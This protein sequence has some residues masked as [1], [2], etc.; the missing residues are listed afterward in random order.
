MVLVERQQLRNYESVREEIYGPI[1]DRFKWEWEKNEEHN[2][3]YALASAHLVTESFVQ[4]LNTATD[5]MG[6]VFSKTVSVMEKAP[7]ETL[8]ELG[9]PAE[10]VD[11]VRCSPF[12]LPTLIGRFDFARTPEGLK[13][14]ELNADTPCAIV[15][16]FLGNQAVCGCLGLKDPNKSTYGDIKQLFSS[17]VKKYKQLGYAVENVFF[18]S[19]EYHEEDKGTTEFLLQESGL[20]GRYV[21]LK[22][23]RLCGDGLYALIEDELIRVDVLYRLHPLCH[24][25]EDNDTDGFR[26]GIETLKLVL[27][28]KLALINPPNALIAQT[29]ALQGLIWAL[30]ESNEF[31]T[32]E[33]HEAIEKYMIPTYFENVFAGE[34]RYVE[35]AIFGREGCAVAI[36]EEDG[37]LFDKDHLPYYWDQQKIYQQYVEMDMTTVETTTGYIT[38]KILWGSFYINGKS[39]AIT[40]R[41]GGNITNVDAKFLPLGIREE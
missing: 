6:Q 11:F 18:S 33:E 12:G 22:D 5:M 37:T 32:K 40:A 31:Y 39:S 25:V 26:T 10:L 15:E 17:A 27:E 30:H 20:N 28:K 34:S 24:F 35:K 41:L 38:G 14:L 8:I 29:K 19:V 3:E 21:P 23:L 36:F 4:E 9:I 13:L 2:R 7:D 1:R 16:A